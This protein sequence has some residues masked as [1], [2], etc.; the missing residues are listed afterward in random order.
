[1]PTR[2]QMSAWIAAAVVPTSRH[3]RAP[4]RGFANMS[5]TPV[6]ATAMLHRPTRTA[7]RHQRIRRP[8]A[9]DAV[10]PA[11]TRAARVR[12]ATATRAR[13]KAACPDMPTATRRHPTRTGARPKSS[14]RV[15]ACAMLVLAA[16]RRPDTATAP[17]AKRGRVLTRVALPDGPIAT[18]RRPTRT[19]AIHRCL[20]YSIAQ[21]AVR[22]ATRRR[23]CRLA[24]AELAATRA[25]RDVPIATLGHHRTATVANA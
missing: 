17:T 8:T 4:T 25:A 1:M 16:T 7:A 11:T 21:G 22:L 14:A 12:R 3:P 5:A 10:G 2:K 24:T 13:T 18:Q 6:G 20:Q 23:G 15:A 19:A 9:A